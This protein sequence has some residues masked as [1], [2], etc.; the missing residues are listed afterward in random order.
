MQSQEYDASDLENARTE[1]EAG[2]NVLAPNW[3]TRFGPGGSNVVGRLIEDI[4]ALGWQLVTYAVSTDGAGHQHVRPLFRRADPT[5]APG[6][7]AL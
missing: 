4:E 1:W 5:R 3:L 7:R 6:R 2:A